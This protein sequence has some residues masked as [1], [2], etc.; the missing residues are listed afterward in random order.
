MKLAESFERV[1]TG[2][3]TF[4]L[5]PCVVDIGKALNVRSG[6]AMPYVICAI[7]AVSVL[8]IDVNAASASTATNYNPNFALFF[9]GGVD[10]GAEHVEGVFK[11]HSRILGLF[12]RFLGLDESKAVVIN[13]VVFDFLW[14]QQLEVITPFEEFT[15]EGGF[16]AESASRVF[17]DQLGCI[18]VVVSLDRL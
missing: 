17:K 10:V 13:R 1:N 15:E 5:R 14:E 9:D 18:S 11:G 12:G 3:S 8:E 6:D 7:N 16:T 4:N 2:E